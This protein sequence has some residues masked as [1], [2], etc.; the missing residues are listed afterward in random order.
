MHLRQGIM[1]I[2]L[3]I[4]GSSS[5]AIS[6]IA[7]SDPSFWASRDIRIESNND[8][9]RVRVGIWDSGVAMNLFEGRIA[10]DRVGRPLVRG[11][12]AFK[13][14]QDS[15]LALLPKSLI[16]RQDEL[17]QIL[18]AFDDIDSGVKSPAA[19]AMNAKLDGMTKPQLAEFDDAV[20]RWSGYSHGTSVADIALA[21]HNQAEIVVAR[22]EWWHGT[23]PVPCWTKELADREARSMRDLLRF[24]VQNGARVINM[25]WGRF[26]TAYIR[27]LEQCAPNMAPPERKALAQ[28]TVERIRADLKR[29]MTAAPHV[30]FVGAAGNN[31]SSLEATNPATRFS[32]PNFILV[33]AVDAT[34]ALTDYSNKG[35]EVSIYANGHRVPARLPGGVQSYPTGTSMAA[36]NVTNAAAKMLAVNS[37]LSG[38]DLKNL[39]IETAEANSTG[40]PLL[41]TRR[42]VQ[43]ARQHVAR[44]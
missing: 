24:M 35:K 14:R 17:N 4:A 30:L 19:T 2:A 28:Y 23:P 21:G 37:R 22:M 18:L 27:N 40:Q 33:G 8:A 12:D 34:G 39:I 44:R 16:D 13:R 36:P 25:S 29:G 3:A 20:G 42:A 26:E 10:K 9:P 7:T 1:L 41:N 38:R 31:G 5:L 32:L 6:Q 15:P 11:Y 43:V